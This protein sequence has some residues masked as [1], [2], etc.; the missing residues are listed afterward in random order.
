MW[1]FKHLFDHWLSYVAYSHKYNS[2]LILKDATNYNECDSSIKYFVCSFQLTSFQ[3][4]NRHR[5][6]S[7]SRI[8]T[9]C[10]NKL[11]KS[12]ISI[13]FQTKAE[14]FCYSALV[15]RVGFNQKPLIVL[16]IKEI[17]LRRIDLDRGCCQF[18]GKSISNDGTL[19]LFS[20]TNTQFY[21]EAFSAQ[22]GDKQVIT[23]WDMFKI[24]L[25]NDNY[26]ETL[27]KY[28]DFFNKSPYIVWL[29][30]GLICLEVKLKYYW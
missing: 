13:L 2:V 6:V 14:L 19:G 30:Q 22:L 7:K 25:I 29:L 15:Q 11:R 8:F 23:I 5:K 18:I 12:N 17:R 26:L 27:L 28:E 9:K 16:Q 1:I 21:F 24:L 20:C 4:N 10:L 3:N